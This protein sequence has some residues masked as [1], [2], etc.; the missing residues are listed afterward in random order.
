RSTIDVE[1]NQLL[2]WTLYT[3]AH[4]G[5]C[6]SRSH[7]IVGRAWRTLRGSVTLKPFTAADCVQRSYHRMNQD[8]ASLHAL[9]RFFLA[10]SGP[11]HQRGDRPTLPFLVNMDRLFEQFVAEWLTCHLPG[12]LTVRAQQ[13]VDVDRRTRVYFNIDLVLYDLNS[14]EVL[15]V[16]DTKYKDAER[17][18]SEDLAQIVAY[19]QSLGCRR[20]LLIYP[21]MFEHDFV[22]QIG[23]VRIERAAFALDGDLER[24]GQRLL[25]TLAT[26]E[27]STGK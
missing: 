21:V 1:D 16:L 24:N 3:I 11:Q 8:Y 5:L 9:C 18:A 19:A 7:T 27:K 2:A 22:V 15:A 26:L 13:R 4:S 14:S 6:G 20:A 17:P 25:A 23:D 10:H 12:S